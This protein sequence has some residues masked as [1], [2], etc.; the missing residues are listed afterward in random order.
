MKALILAGGLGTR[1]RSEVTDVPK[2]MAPVDGTPFLEYLIRQLSKHRITDI[3]LCVGYKLDSIRSYFENGNRWDVRLS[4]AVENASLGTGGA[5]REAMHRSD[6]DQYLI[7]NGDSYIDV[8]LNAFLVYHRRKKGCASI[9][10]KPLSDTD[11]YGRVDMNA[12]GR[13]TN[14]KEKQ[15]G[16][17][18][19]INCGVYILN[20]NCLDQFQPHTCSFES[21]VLPA[22]V[23]SGLY[24]MVQDSFFIDIGI[25]EDY[26]VICHDASML[27]GT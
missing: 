13:I 8:D 14:F 21:E 23:G 18:G 1:L 3:V 22:L 9:L 19:L 27:P 6:D 26:R 4:Y 12:Q 16:R 15:G 25:P 20:R 10:L 7:L 5:I 24:G 2:P 11:R 17:S